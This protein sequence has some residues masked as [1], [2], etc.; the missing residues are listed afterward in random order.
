MNYQANSYQEY[1]QTTHPSR[2]V[3]P[4][5]IGGPVNN[6]INERHA[7]PFLDYQ[8]A[9][10]VRTPQSSFYKDRD[11]ASFADSRIE[12]TP[13]YK[14]RRDSENRN[15]M[16]GFQNSGIQQGSIQGSK[17][18]TTDIRFK[19]TSELSSSRY[20]TSSKQSR[21]SPLRQVYDES[22]SPSVIS[23]MNTGI[24]ELLREQIKVDEEITTLNTAYQSI[25][26]ANSTR[27]EEFVSNLKDRLCKLS[28]QFKGI[29]ETLEIDKLDSD[30][31][32]FDAK[33]K[34]AGRWI[35]DLKGKVEDR[36]MTFRQLYKIN[37]K[38]I[39]GHRAEEY[40]SKKATEIEAENVR[41]KESLQTRKNVYDREAHE[42]E[43]RIAELDRQLK[44]KESEWIIKDH[45][46]T[47]FIE[48]EAREEMNRQSY[49][50]VLKYFEQYKNN[51]QEYSIAN[52]QFQELFAIWR[53]YKD[54]YE[55]AR[56]MTDEKALY[57][58][59]Q[60]LER[61]KAEKLKSRMVN[62]SWRQYN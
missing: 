13:N 49:E 14:Y 55:E 8:I 17:I 41:M 3:S 43:Q 33:T 44:E 11:S 35:Q 21:Y 18:G 60:K 36:E 12:K 6:S 45:Q 7:A 38:N 22:R 62:R 54:Q 50:L 2:S 28:D 15:L 24:N 51:S 26:R 40:L 53:F 57:E 58:E 31:E 59:I 29:L 4:I 27:L 34:M 47:V 23:H 30:K 48:Q 25:T 9:P 16:G 20:G 10:P 37:Q 5:G 42:L 46:H 56:L 32:L 1:S 19:D 52:K 61:F 39:P